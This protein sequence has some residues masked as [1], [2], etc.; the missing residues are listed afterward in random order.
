MIGTFYTIAGRVNL[1]RV[2]FVGNF[3]GVV[4]YSELSEEEIYFE[5][6]ISNFKIIRNFSKEEEE[7]GMREVL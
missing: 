6:L 5:G 3:K 7:E 4:E 2:R 1:E